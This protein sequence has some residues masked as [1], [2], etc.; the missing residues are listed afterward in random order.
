M[1][2]SS[3][4]LPKIACHGNVLKESEKGSGSI[5]FKKYLPFGDEIV[6]IG[7]VDPEIISSNQSKKKEINASK[8]YTGSSVG[9][10]SVSK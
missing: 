1:K 2:V 10:H 6:K 7:P 9:T 3:P 4:I 8:I 5:K